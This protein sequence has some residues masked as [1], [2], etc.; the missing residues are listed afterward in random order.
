LDQT[1]I[2]HIWLITSV[3]NCSFEVKARITAY[4]RS[5][6]FPAGKPPRIIDIQPG[7]YLTNYLISSPPRPC[8]D[9]ANTYIFSLA[10]APES[11][12]PVID[13]EEDYGN[14]VVGP[15]EWALAGS[16]EEARW[17]EVKTV[18]AAPAYITPAEMAQVFQQGV[19]NPRA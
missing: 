17:E 2:F 5:L 11:E 12:L 9:D 6:L 3:P 1:F 18:H 13:M 10:V 8:P 16:D 15:L 4:G 7:A 14:Y 19:S